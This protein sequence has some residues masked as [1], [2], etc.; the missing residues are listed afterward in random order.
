M[1]TYI[2]TYSPDDNKLRLY[3]STR[4]DAETFLRVKA[5]GFKWAPRQDLFV[6]PM[7][8]PQRADLLTELAGDIDDEDTSLV[9]RAEERAERFEGYSESRAGDAENA[10]ATV[11]RIADGIPLG[12]PIL[13]GHHSERHARKDA[14]R[15]QNGMRRAIKLWETSQY[16]QR[17]AAGAVAHAKYKELPGVRAR[18]IKGL[19]ADRR[20]HERTVKEAQ[21]FGKLW[22][23]PNMT[24]EKALKIA[25]VDRRLG[26]DV[27]GRLD[28]GTLD[29]QEA[30]AN[31]IDA[32]G[33]IIVWAERWIAHID[34]RLGYEKAML[35]EAGGMR[36]LEKPK[37]AALPSMANFPGE[38]YVSITKGEWARIPTAFKGTRIVRG[39]RVRT[40]MVRGGLSAIY[41]SD[42]KR[43]DPPQAEGSDTPAR[44]KESPAP[45]MQTRPAPPAAEPNAF[46]AMKASLRAGVKVVSAPDLFPTPPELAA[47]MVEALGL[48]AGDSV[49]E[50]S[51]G[52]GNLLRALG[53][54]VGLITAVEIDGALHTDLA[55]RFPDVR[56]FGANFLYLTTQNLGWY[57]AIIMNPPF[58][59]GADIAHIIHALGFLRPG[60]RLVALCAA[61]PH[62]VKQ[63]KHLGRWEAL[64]QGSFKSAGTNVNVAMLVVEK[65]LNA[66]TAA[67][68]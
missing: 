11:S 27:W 66:A 41:L 29:P 47:R 35:A 22:A 42:S 61:G 1:T 25:N 8:T 14:E 34:L 40:A 24:R 55:H 19:E 67:G 59:G 46:D 51:A 3:A 37:R 56:C 23:Q 4:L 54:H 65:D 30:A 32:N 5:A 18:R 63:L 58:S 36:L 57:D 38:G 33:K 31:A 9:D 52:T 50:P 44:F 43:V 49:L 28:K 62:Q 15:I 68:V 6:A 2:A 20:R 60:G 13:V 45:E 64:P 21:T 26:F 39:A 48:E 53:K 10:R 12:Q 7:W 17:R 16:W